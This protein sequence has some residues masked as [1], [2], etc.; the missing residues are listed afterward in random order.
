VTSPVAHPRAIPGRPR[1]CFICGVEVG[2][3]VSLAAGADVVC[4]SPH[5]RMPMLRRAHVSPEAF[6]LLLEVHRRQRREQQR[7]AERNAREALEH[8]SIREAVNRQEWL[9]ASHYPLVVLPAAPHGLA[10]LSRERRQRYREHLDEII[11]EAVAGEDNDVEAV[12]ALADTAAD[13]IPLAG[14][15][16]ALCRGGC[17]S[18]GG[19]KAYLDP[20]TM[21]RFM[22]LRPEVPADRVAEEYLDRLP[23]QT[24][25]GSCVNHTATGCS[26]S[27]EMRA[28]TCNAYYCTSL[29]G[30]Q[31]R[32]A[33]GETPL[34]AFVIQRGQNSWNTD[35]TD[36]AHDVLSTSV[37]TESGA[38]GLQAEASTDAVLDP[39]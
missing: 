7:L 26:L 18:M 4:E 19:E 9:P 27:R 20:A 22:R 15:L 11:A 13:L 29:R 24:V 30:W 10:L 33:S 3:H 5:C 8:E 12:P 25:A 38:R 6:R 2:L 37:V 36:V 21:R 32:C 34:G 17:C 16:C 23:D 35:R 1:T 28:D 39:C 31:A 14:P